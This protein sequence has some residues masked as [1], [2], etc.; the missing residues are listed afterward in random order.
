MKAL[1]GSNAARDLRSTYY[2]MRQGRDLNPHAVVAA[3]AVLRTVALPNSATLAS[4]KGH[5]VYGIVEGLTS[6]V[7]HIG[8]LQGLP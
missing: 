7:E 2:E 4:F 8:S 6:G 5:I 3:S 1:D